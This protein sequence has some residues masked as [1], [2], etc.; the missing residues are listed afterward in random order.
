MKILMPYISRN[1]SDIHSSVIVG[2]IEKFGKNV[3]EM[4]PDD[5]IPVRISK[6][7]RKEKKT[8]QIYQE[9]IEKYQP[10][11][12]L[13]NDIDA[14]FFQP[15]IKRNIPTISIIHEPILRDIRYLQMFDTLLNFTESGG[16]L[17]FVSELQFKHFQ[18]NIKRVTG[19][20]LTD[21]KG[22][23]NSS[24]STG[25]ETPS[26]EILYD[27]V[28]VGRNDPS[29]N[30]F[31]LHK[32]L[33]TTKLKTC[34]LTSEELVTKKEEYTKYYNV[35][36]KWS[37]PNFT[38]KGLNHDD[39]MEIVSKST[40]FVSTFPNESFGI[41]VLEALSYGTPV[42]LLTDKSGNHASECIPASPEHY[43]KV[44]KTIE[45]FELAK[46]VENFSKLTYED[47]LKI[48]NMT[49]EKHNKNKYLQQ[50]EF[51]FAERLRDNS[52]KTGLELFFS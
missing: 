37:E 16:H 18:E 17:Y 52:E 20:D 31:L 49:K 38:F 48:S 32:K 13:L 33:H 8:K 4:F 21:I 27:A 51:M 47:R 41:T 1:N 3:Y 34:V 9:A 36:S 29:K 23:I 30:P 42:I 44:H 12:I 45:P 19:K 10:D 43:R 5:I 2:G 35:N 50:F 11:M 6:D 14:L 46:I 22:Y 28:T 15:Q 25:N 40:C 26:T 39:T 7:D 24:F